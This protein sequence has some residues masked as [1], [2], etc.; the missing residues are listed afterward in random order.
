MFSSHRNF[1][2]RHS[3]AGSELL[4]LRW[5]PISPESGSQ[6]PMPLMAG[7]KRCRDAYGETLQAQ[8]QA[9]ARRGSTYDSA[10]LLLHCGF[11][12]L[13][14][15]SNDDSG[16]EMAADGANGRAKPL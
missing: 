3:W 11:V 5:E 12:F 1:R 7:Y 14:T 8:A 16:P 9:L 4:L 6:S 13:G 2:K 15:H 10:P